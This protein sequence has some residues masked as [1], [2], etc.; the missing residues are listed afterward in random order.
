MQS[1]VFKAREDGKLYVDDWPE[2]CTVGDY[3]LANA[4]PRTFERNGEFVTIQVANG[5]AHYWC[6][7]RLPLA[8]MTIFE[9]SGGA[10]I[11]K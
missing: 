7:E 2:V 10:Y 5:Y 4:P 11:F 1:L 8:Q 3:L 6:R 9:I